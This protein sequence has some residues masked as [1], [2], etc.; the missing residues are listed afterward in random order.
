YQTYAELENFKSELAVSQFGHPYSSVTNIQSPSADKVASGFGGFSLWGRSSSTV[1]SSSSSLTNS[2]DPSSKKDDSSVDG[3]DVVSTSPLL[4]LLLT[5]FILPLPGVVAL[6]RD[7]WRIRAQGLL[8]RLG[9]AELSESYDKGALGARKTL[10][11]GASVIM[12][13]IGRGLLGGAVRTSEETNKSSSTYDV[14][15]AQDLIRGWDYMVDQLVYGDLNDSIFEHFAKTEDLDS[16]SPTIRAAV[17]Y[18]IFHLS[19]LFHAV[20]IKSPEGQYLLKLIENVNNLIPYKMIGQTL[21]IGNAATMINGMM[22]LLLAKLSVTGVTNWVGLTASEDDGMNLLQRIIS[23]VL[24]WD[25]SEFK[26]IV[27]K[28]EKAKDGPTPEMLKA[29]RDYIQQDRKEHELVRDVSCKVSQSVIV[30]IFNSTNPEL[31]ATVTDAQHTQCLEYYSALLSVRDRERIAAA[32]CRETPDLF[33]Q[34]VRDGVA[35]CDPMIRSV[36]ERVDLRE[37][38]DGLQGFISDFIKTSTPKKGGTVSI[39]D[40][41][42]LLRRSRPILHRW[43]HAIA[44]KCPD[45]WEEIRVWCN[46]SLHSFRKDVA[47]STDTSTAT[48]QM[49]QKL[50]D[51]Y[52]AVNDS[53]KEQVISAID[54]HVSYLSTLKSISLAK[55]QYIVTMSNESTPDDTNEGPGIYLA[56]WQSLLDKTPI[57]P[58]EPGQTSSLR[59]G[60]D[61]RHTTTMG[62]IGIGGTKNLQS[63]A[64][65]GPEAPDVSIVTDKLSDPFRDL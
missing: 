49:D 6:P 25:A 64:N 12:E 32:L 53:A 50:N 56:R 2:D 34:L 5:K 45:I 62:K 46:N 40:Y 36:H 29:I 17:E 14:N 24:S 57:T 37:H 41:V 8:Y 51:L 63:R 21:R 7:F 1:A 59:Y 33:T 43:I 54:S 38:L 18:A 44:S 22:R 31:A 4:Q 11:T 35:A 52:T 61:V 58:A 15:Q 10:A 9:K 27:D 39:E 28:T 26:K 23:L 42:A 20:F 47:Q 16:H 65:F 13:N 55:L 30:A 3:Q 48:G 19:T 60:K